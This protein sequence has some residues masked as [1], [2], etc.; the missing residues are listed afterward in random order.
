MGTNYY[1]HVQ[2][3]AVV[4]NGQQ[5]LLPNF[6]DSSTLHIG[7]SSCGWCFALHVI[8]D[9][10]INDLK[11]WETFIMD[12]EGILKDEYD[13]KVSLDNLLQV[14]TQRKQD[15]LR[16]QPCNRYVKQGKGTWDCL[17]GNFS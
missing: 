16:H 7:K 4:I 11:D 3:E 8:P 14:I 2:Q 6:K 13:T 15:S 12:N 9:L 5:E 1:F 17:C 10:D